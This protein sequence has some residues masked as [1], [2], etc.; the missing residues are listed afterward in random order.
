VIDWKSPTTRRREYAEIDKRERGLRGWWRRWSPSWCSKSSRLGFYEGED[1]SDAGSVRR[2]R[3]ELPDEDMSI[4]VQENEKGMNLAEGKTRF[5]WR[6][7]SSSWSC[8]NLGE[9]PSRRLSTV[10]LTK[11]RNSPYPQ[12]V[13]GCLDEKHRD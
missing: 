5:P 2:Y 13:W 9:E 6:R 11:D 10:S 4:N 12:A 1:N 8:F 3:L 7:M